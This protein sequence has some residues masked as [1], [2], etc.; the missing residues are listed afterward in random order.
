MLLF[1]WQHNIFVVKGYEGSKQVEK[2]FNLPCPE[3]CALKPTMLLKFNL[4]NTRQDACVGAS[5]VLANGLSVVSW[6]G[7]RT[8]GTALQS[9][10]QGVHLTRLSSAGPALVRDAMD[11]GAQA[12]KPPELMCDDPPDVATLLPLP[13][14]HGTRLCGCC[15]PRRVTRSDGCHS[16]GQQT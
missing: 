4:K 6:C 2:L 8:R 3:Y 9:L 13:V 16:R 11:G 15:V 12:S 5:V 7:T 1:Q 14:L 10:T